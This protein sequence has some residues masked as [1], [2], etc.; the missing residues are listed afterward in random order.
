M[1]KSISCFKLSDTNIL[2]SGQAAKLLGVSTRTMT[3]WLDAGIVHSWKVNK[4]RRIL[5]EQLFKLAEIKR[6][7]I[8][9]EKPSSRE[10][11]T[12]VEAGTENEEIVDAK[13]I[14][15]F[16]EQELISLREKVVYL[17]RKLL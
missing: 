15:A 14:G 13:R 4:E 10:F 17:F 5:R 6:M 11:I 7:P 12:G 8:L 2:S 9:Y 3:S 16:Y 1:R